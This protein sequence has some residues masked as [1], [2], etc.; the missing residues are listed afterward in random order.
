MSIGA[1]CGISWPRDRL[2]IQVLDD[3]TDQ[4][5]KVNSKLLDNKNIKFLLSKVNKNNKSHFK[6]KWLRIYIFTQTICEPL[7][8]PF[9]TLLYLFINDRIYLSLELNFI[10]YIIKTFILNYFI[11]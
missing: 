1:V 11:K 8:P 4:T 2:V 7:R 10:F 3:S 6:F 5:I 9:S